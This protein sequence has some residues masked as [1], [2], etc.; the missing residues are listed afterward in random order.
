MISLDR[1]DLS[2]QVHAANTGHAADTGYAVHGGTRD[3]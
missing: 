3:R 1:Y 2:G